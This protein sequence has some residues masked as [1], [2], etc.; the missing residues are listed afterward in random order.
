[1]RLAF[2]RHTSVDEVR[3]TE[4]QTKKVVVVVVELDG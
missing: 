2:S 4:R 1:M 3:G